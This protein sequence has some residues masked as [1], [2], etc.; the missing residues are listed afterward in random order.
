MSTHLIP[1]LLICLTCCLILPACG[2]KAASESSTN[3]DGE[4]MQQQETEGSYRIVLK[5]LNGSE[6][7]GAGSIKIAEDEVAV[8]LKMIQSHSRTKHFQSIS[9]KGNCP[10]VEDD[11]NGD[12]YIDIQEGIVA[13]GKALIP[14]DD[15]LNSQTAGNKDLPIS[16]GSGFY[17]YSGKASLQQLLQDLKKPDDER[18]D[19]LVKL[20]PYE[21]LNLAGR[22]I[23]VYGVPSSTHLPESIATRD[24]L[25][26]QASLPIACG[27][28]VRIN[29][30]E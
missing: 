18:E 11:L 1:S 8:Q 26:P 25:S 22:H 14:L 21:E 3:S 4:V 2:K 13:Y 5:G 24:E 9:Y 29:P 15:D 6:A 10:T 12:G 23:I 16:D 7:S 20:Q 30:E 27:E 28:I 17:E 19:L